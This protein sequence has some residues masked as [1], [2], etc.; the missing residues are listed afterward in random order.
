MSLDPAARSPFRP[1]RAFHAAVSIAALIP[2][3]AH[4]ALPCFQD[5]R[6][7]LEP[8]GLTAHRPQ[9][10]AGYFPFARTSVPELQEDDPVLGPG[11]RR[12]GP[13]EIDPAGED[14]LVEV[15]V[16]RVLRGTALV[17][18]RSGPE[19]AVWT[20]RT[21]QPGT[22]VPFTGM[23]SQPLS[24]GGDPS[25]HVWVEWTGT[26]HGTRRLSLEADGSGILLDRLTFHSFRSI[27]V[28]LGGEGQSPSLPL[29]PNHGT[30]V[31]GTE[32]YELG[33]DVHMYDEDGVTST[34]SG[35]V[36]DEVVNSVQSRGVADVAVFGYSHG[37]GSTHDLA[38]RLDAFR[39]GIGTFAIPF[40]SYVDGV[41]NDSDIDTD[42][43]LRYPPSSA[44]HANH[45]QRGTF[46]DFFLD[47]GPVPGSSP[48]PSGLDVETTTWGAGATHFIVDDFMQVRDFILLNLD[49]RTTR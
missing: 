8:A 1:V 26:A 47:G 19:L 29:D 20:T 48:P 6:A 2:A 7:S 33:Y 28:A 49:L 32:L 38:E 25:L 12:N 5:T 13:G 40:T 35:P 17:L 27:V 46:A 3:T 14:D 30:F 41:E 15:V 45:Y 18:E 22:Q 34:G 44:F 10:G 16:G 9:H 31:V 23:R 36:Y 37:G 43:E 39:A 4:P 24:F 21:R 11:I 42:P